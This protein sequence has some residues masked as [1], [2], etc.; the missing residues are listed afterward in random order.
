M[1]TYDSATG[2][3]ILFGGNQLDDRTW[4]WNGVTWAQLSTGTNPHTRFFAGMDFD[5]AT[6]SVVLFGG[7][8]GGTNYLGDTWNWAYP[9]STPVGWTHLSP[10]SSPSVRENAA[11]E[12]DPATG[13]TVLFGGEVGTT[14]LGDT[15]VWN[16]SSWQQ[17]FTSTAPSARAGAAMAYDPALGKLFLFGG[18]NGTKYFDD[19]WWWNGSNWASIGYGTVPSGRTGASM[20]YDSALNTMVLFGG[21]NTT[22]GYLNDLWYLG[23]GWKQPTVQSGSPPARAFAGVAYDSAPSSRSLIVF[24][25][26]SNS[27]SLNDTWE[28]D[29]SRWGQY[30]PS[31][32]PPAMYGQSMAYDQGTGYLTLFG[33]FTTSGY[34]NATWQWNGTW[35]EASTT[36]P[37][38]R[39]LAAM[40]YDSGTG[41]LVMVGGNAGGT[42][43]NDTW[44]WDQT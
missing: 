1:M 28:W 17:V 22:Q 43:Q 15:W 40:A 3:A 26:D 2:N 38:A 37:S 14:V 8:E 27:G 23:S 10:T 13:Q 29:G 36:G 5:Q 33:G 9:S 18:T 4:S 32:S 30:V 20:T 34:T 44:I 21:Y 31:A 41:N 7:D 35:V 16:G 39:E 12:F 6:A 24:G 19:L 25:G 11:M 42:L